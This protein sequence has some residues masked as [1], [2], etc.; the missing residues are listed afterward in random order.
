VAEHDGI[1][2]EGLHDPAVHVSGQDS[3]EVLVD[4]ARRAP[5]RDTALS[6][7]D[8]RDPAGVEV[9]ELGQA[10]TLV[11][12]R[13]AGVGDPRLVHLVPSSGIVD[14]AVSATSPAPVI[15]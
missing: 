2:F 13:F 11:G 15:P 5:R 12:H 8:K 14:A 6:L 7:H 3:S 10:A 9:Q 4:E 1:V